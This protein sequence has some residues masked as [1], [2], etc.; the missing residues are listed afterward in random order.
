VTTTNPPAPGRDA[1]PPQA[2]QP[3]AKDVVLAPRTV[4]A[5]LA[6]GVPGRA[7]QLLTSDLVYDSA[8][9]AVLA[10]LRELHPQADG[11]GLAGCLCPRTAPTSHPR[12][13][14]KSS[15]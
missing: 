3:E 14:Q 7:L 11:R 1:P 10:R 9:P 15:L 6:E 8:D 13:H 5:L 4:R 12:G 2:T